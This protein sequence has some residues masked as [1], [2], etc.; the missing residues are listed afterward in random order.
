MYLAYLSNK[1]NK[2]YAVMIITKKMIL[3]RSHHD[4]KIATLSD[5]SLRIRG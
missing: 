5:G 1:V 3:N 2:Y 4:K